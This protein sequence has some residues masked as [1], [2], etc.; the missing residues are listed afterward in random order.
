M[1]GL[2][3]PFDQKDEEV[4]VT[5][6]QRQLMPFTDEQPAVCRKGEVA[7]AIAGHGY[8]TFDIVS[9]PASVR[10]TVS[11]HRGPRRGGP[12]GPPHRNRNGRLPAVLV[13]GAPRR[14]FAN[15]L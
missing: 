14:P 12:P 2:M 15:L 9:K 5:R 13:I 10:P 4:E 6:N 8:R 11:P 7:E 3:T 1:H